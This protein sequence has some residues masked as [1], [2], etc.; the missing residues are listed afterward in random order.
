MVNND[1][2]KL[3]F[4]AVTKCRTVVIDEETEKTLAAEQCGLSRS[5]KHEES[6]LEKA[7]SNRG[8]RRFCTI[9]DE[10]DKVRGAKER[11]AMLDEERIVI[12]EEV[13]TMLEFEKERLKTG[14]PKVKGSEYNEDD[15]TIP[16]YKQDEKLKNVTDV[17]LHLQEYHIC[18]RGASPKKDA[19]KT[20]PRE[21]LRGVMSISRLSNRYDVAKVE[22]RCSYNLPGKDAEKMMSLQD[23]KT[24]RTEA[25]WGIMSSGQF[26]TRDEVPEVR[27][28]SQEQV[29]KPRL[30]SPKRDAVTSSGGNTFRGEARLATTSKGHLSHRD[31]DSNYRDEVTELGTSRQEQV[32]K[33]RR[34]S[35]RKDNEKMMSP[36]Q[37][38]VKREALWNVTSKGQ[39]SNR[40]D[41]KR[42]LEALKNYTK[43]DVKKRQEAKERKEQIRLEAEEARKKSFMKRQAVDEE[44]N[45]EEARD[46]E[47]KED[48]KR[49]ALAR[50]EFEEAARRRA[51]KA[52]DEAKKS[53]I[54]RKDAA[55]QEKRAMALIEESRKEELWRQE[56]EEETQKLELLRREAEGEA[57][58]HEL[59]L[60]VA[61]EKVQ[62][63]DLPRALRIEKE[64]R[65]KDFPREQGDEDLLQQ[66]I[67]HSMEMKDETRRQEF[68]RRKVEEKAT[69]QIVEV[70]GLDGSR[71]EGEETDN[72]GALPAVHVEIEARRIPL[73]GEVEGPR[74]CV[75][76]L[77]EEAAV[78][79]F[80]MES[81]RKEEEKEK[82]K[83]EEVR[84]MLMI[85]EARRKELLKGEYEELA[86]N[87]D[88]AWA[89]EVEEARRRVEMLR[90]DI[91]GNVTKQGIQ[92]KK[93]VLEV[94]SKVLSNRIDAI[95]LE[96]EMEIEEVWKGENNKEPQALEGTNKGLARVTTEEESMQRLDL[97]RF[98]TMD[99]DVE[100]EHAK[101]RLALL[102]RE[103][104]EGDQRQE[105]ECWKQM[106]G[107]FGEENRTP[108]SLRRRNIVKLASG[109]EKQVKQRHEVLVTKDNVLQE[110]TTRRQ[111]MQKEVYRKQRAELEPRIVDEERKLQDT[112]R[113]QETLENEL[114]EEEDEYVVQCAGDLEEGLVEL[115]EYDKDM[116]LRH[117]SSI[118]MAEET[119]SQVDTSEY[120]DVEERNFLE[121]RRENEVVQ[122]D[123]TLRGM[124]GQKARTLER[125]V[126]NET[127][128]RSP[129]AEAYRGSFL[130]MRA[131]EETLKQKPEAAWLEFVNQAEL[132]EVEEKRSIDLSLVDLE[133]KL[134][135]L[136][137]I[138]T[139]GTC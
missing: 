56:A 138:P 100:L 42:K 32:I 130:T 108:D 86:Q 5:Q 77:K 18:S 85:E 106:E 117:E 35:P 11:G 101:Q 120:R 116:K 112:R 61:C 15:S 134:E 19:E 54:Q 118:A 78:E 79:S 62:V 34:N 104:M 45:R 4:E 55:K 65:S 71:K 113:R 69:K 41:V 109:R 72:K 93:V 124:G 24:F 75:E 1:K 44:R 46:M 57:G 10:G 59:M 98:S 88:K 36:R 89:I 139:S 73:S 135:L 9:P 21:C 40:E 97:L 126:G 95:T 80:K 136:E 102:R 30:I 8:Q 50:K 111:G 47:V 43:E 64:T 105:A 114:V 127:D 129:M 17:G 31:V 91:E 103:A 29:N 27:L 22:P 67:V 94:R 58:K 13:Q 37:D 137:T 125:N 53:G 51:K 96:K 28:K 33:S 14:I 2:K 92:A 3:E 84:A 123:E 68:L 87:K 81:L 16:E 74:D 52:K 63:Q 66:E 121:R 131:E 133:K 6:T 115:E 107:N 128:A 39:L 122:N 26:G 110:E 119:R 76:L 83:R 49:K 23:Q 20:S 7:T 38:T 12:I 132:L 25:L 82:R 48:A 99:E 70:R 60:G 90:K